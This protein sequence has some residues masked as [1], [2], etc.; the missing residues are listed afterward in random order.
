MPIGNGLLSPYHLEA[1]TLPGEYRIS[2]YATDYCQMVMSL[3]R[4]N[5]DKEKEDKKDMWREG[6]RKGAN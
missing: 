4:N 1:G 6:R 5:K 2:K 3:W